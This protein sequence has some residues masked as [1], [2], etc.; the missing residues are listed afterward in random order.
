MSIFK[1]KPKVWKLNPKQLTIEQVEEKSGVKLTYPYQFLKG[2]I[3]D[4]KYKEL[5]NFGCSDI[6]CG[7]HWMHRDCW[8]NCN[9]CNYYPIVEK[10]NKENN[11]PKD[12]ETDYVK[13]GDILSIF[14]NKEEKNDEKN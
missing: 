2:D 6:M 8:S 4:E 14:E 3:D 10:Y 1:R 13:A 5:K 12:M 7:T 9:D 11:I